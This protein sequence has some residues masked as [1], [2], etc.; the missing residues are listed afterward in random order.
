[1]TGGET[2]RRVLDAL[3]VAYLA[4]LGQ[5]HHGAVHALTA[6]GRHVVTRPG[7]FGDT[8]SLLRIDFLWFARGGRDWRDAPMDDQ[9]SLGVMRPWTTRRRSSGGAVTY[10]CHVCGSPTSA[11]TW[12]P[13]PRTTR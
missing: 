3:G 9:A 2:A 13:A 5:I 1:M 4:P 6:D 8:D 10:D 12:P 11:P 7:S